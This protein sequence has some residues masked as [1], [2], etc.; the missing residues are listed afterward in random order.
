M[1]PEEEI[2][3]SGYGVH[4]P[5]CLRAWGRCTCPEPK[6]T[7]VGGYYTI[8]D[9]GYFIRVLQREIEQ[10]KARVVELENENGSASNEAEKAAISSPVE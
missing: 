8:A 1:T 2:Q 4:C 9:I 10:L 3:R 5:V 6:P 7:P